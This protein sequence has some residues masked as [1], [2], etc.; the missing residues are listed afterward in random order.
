MIHHKI[1][2]MNLKNKWFEEE[3]DAIRNEDAP[4]VL[5]TMYNQDL[6]NN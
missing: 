6:L 5:P 3:E 1:I 2:L 4:K